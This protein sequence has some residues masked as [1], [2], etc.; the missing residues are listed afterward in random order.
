MRFY[1]A[2]TLALASVAAT[3]ACRSAQFEVGA[4]P[5]SVVS[6]SPPDT[7]Q[8]GLRGGRVVTLTRIRFASDTIWGNQDG[9]QRVGVPV[10]DVEWGLARANRRDAARSGITA[11][12][13]GLFVLQ[14]AFIALLLYSFA[15]S[16]VD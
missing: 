7:V 15:H 3:V 14:V 13:V 1:R 4:P 5:P 10:K 6:A 9:G 16:N 8:L 12:L 2:A 11:A